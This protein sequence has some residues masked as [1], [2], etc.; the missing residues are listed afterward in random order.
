MQ[1]QM[2]N[3]YQMQQSNSKDIQPLSSG[4]N[5]HFAAYPPALIRD[6]VLAGCPVGGIILDPFMGTGTTAMVAL[7]YQRHYVGFELNPEYFPII[8]Q[9]IQVTPNMFV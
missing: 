4:S 6:C 3:I 8:K 2:S 7:Q 9:K 5:V 1:T